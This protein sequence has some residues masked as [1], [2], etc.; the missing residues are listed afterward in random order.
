MLPFEMTISK[1][2]TRQEHANITFS[3]SFQLWGIVRALA[4]SKNGIHQILPAWVPR[5][6]LTTLHTC[7]YFLYVK[8]SFAEA[9]CLWEKNVF[10]DFYVVL[11]VRT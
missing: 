9:K 4:D 1:T 3:L 2:L 11:T 7:R 8:M 6:R 10:I 5:L